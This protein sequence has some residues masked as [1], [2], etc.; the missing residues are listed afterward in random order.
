MAVV[1]A[2]DPQAGQAMLER[3]RKRFN[4]GDLILTNLSISVAANLGPGTVGLVVYP[5]D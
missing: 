4:L 2:R 1:H 5:V 3:T